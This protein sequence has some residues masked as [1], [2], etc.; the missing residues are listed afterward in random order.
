MYKI[1]LPDIKEKL[2]KSGKISSQELEEKIK[3][4]INDLS[5][6]ISEEGAAHIIAND[7]GVE[8]LVQGKEKLKIK[9]IYPGMR[10]ISVT[11]K[12]VRKYD[13]REF[14]KGEST[15]KVCSLVVGDETGTIRAVFW[16]D[17][18]IKIKDVQENDIL[19]L[20]QVSVRDNKGN[21]ELHF[22][23]QSKILINPEGET[24]NTIRQSASY[25]R[26]KI[27]ELKEGEEGAEILGTI[28]QVFDPRFFTVCSTCSKRAVESNGVFQCSEHG[29]VQPM[30]SYVLNAMVDDGSGVI[31]S[32]FWKNQTHHL[33]SFSEEKM[34]LFKEN[35][36][37]FEEVKTDLLGEQ[38]RMIGRVKKN[39]MFDRLE[40]SV[41][42][43]EKANPEEELARLQSQVVR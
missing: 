13:I 36:S 5:G 27:E 8:L 6:L 31:R 19:S 38:F 42:I 28:V 9:E 43:V 18:V 15:G 35:L 3:V 1:P 33:L 20:K 7:L 4:K 29:T 26:K 16:N 40:F 39:D 30:L 32:V 11:G 25:Q 23:E 37:A 24:V 17:D 2:V 34:A 14:T 12:I 10:G 41:Q 21:I 22:N